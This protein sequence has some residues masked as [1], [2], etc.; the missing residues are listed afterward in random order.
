MKKARFLLIGLC[1]VALM[2]AYGSSVFAQA[3][4]PTA[5]TSVV[6]IG[7]TVTQ[8]TELVKGWS[9]KKKILGHDVYNDKN[10]KVGKISDL[11]I[12][13]DK[14]SSFAIVEAGGFLGIGRHEVAIPVKQ[15]KEKDGKFILPGATKEAIKGMPEF[16]YAK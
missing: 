7:V 15:F 12:G 10:Q 11:I 16:H 9:V 6:A 5:G 1:V 13:P 3:S 8:L 2:A 4:P 14:A